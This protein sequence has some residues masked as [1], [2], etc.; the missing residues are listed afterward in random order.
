MKLAIVDDYTPRMVDV[1]TGT[2][3]QQ[4]FGILTRIR[5]GLQIWTAQTRAIDRIVHPVILPNRP[6][7]T[8]F[9]VVEGKSFFL[10]IQQ[11]CAPGSTRKQS[12]GNIDVSN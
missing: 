6:Q 10:D 8:M 2:L 9:N 3:L 12:R 4:R 1:F 7:D 11:L 5:S